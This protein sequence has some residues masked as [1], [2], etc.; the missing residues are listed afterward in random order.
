MLTQSNAQVIISQTTVTTTTYH[1]SP[2]Q[3]NHHHY[4]RPVFKPRQLPLRAAMPLQTAYSPVCLQTEQFARI[5]QSIASQPFE[6]SRLQI[7]NQVSASNALTSEQVAA[8]MGVFSFE[9]TRLDFARM[10]YHRVIDPQN[11][12]IVN[13]AF[14]FSSSIDE[15]YQ[16]IM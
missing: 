3:T 9:S 1:P 5:L 13:N 11:Y 7:A 15:L 2:W 6:S 14:R 8:I 16:Y 12:F 10:A 4:P